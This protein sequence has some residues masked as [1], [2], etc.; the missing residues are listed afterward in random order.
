[1]IPV[2]TRKNDPLC[3]FARPVADVAQKTGPASLPGGSINE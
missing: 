1:M 2:V 3:V